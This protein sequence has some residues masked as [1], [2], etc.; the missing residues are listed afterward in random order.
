MNAQPQ[1][2]FEVQT[3]PRVTPSPSSNSANAR[4]RDKFYELAE[5]FA[6]IQS[7]FII[8]TFF[9]KHF[10][11]MWAAMEN[12][13][14]T[15]F[16]VSKDNS[17]PS[18]YKYSVPHIFAAACHNMQIVQAENKTI[19]FA[20]A[21]GE[22]R[23][24]RG[25]F[26]FI[27]DADGTEAGTQSGAARS[28]K[29]MTLED[30]FNVL[31]L[32]S[33]NDHAPRKLELEGG[34]EEDRAIYYQAIKAFNNAVPSDMRFRLDEE[35]KRLVQNA[36]SADNEMA[37]YMSR[38]KQDKSTPAVNYGNMPKG[39][40]IVPDTEAVPQSAQAKEAPAPVKKNAPEPESTQA[41][42]GSA[43]TIPTVSF[44]KATMNGE[45]L[46][47]EDYQNL[48]SRP[49]DP[50]LT[51]AKAFIGSRVYRAHPDEHLPVDLLKIYE[52]AAG[53]HGAS[54]KR[55]DQKEPST[56]PLSELTFPKL[57]DIKSVSG[58]VK[59]YKFGYN[60]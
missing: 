25:T 44:G 41:A 50:Q 26:Q 23:A 10:E 12:T 32:A 19:R 33:F 39:P 55:F 7:G 13:H 49:F 35:L 51:L 59:S 52:S 36:P 4:K 57:P 24:K 34:N 22:I 47:A 54:V 2:T 11:A 46:Q 45:F 40:T 27:P 58:S 17:D 18:T 48:A 9:K 3:G 1:D 21:H 60:L 28:T 14:G 31:M 6:E 5:L 42:F 8:N 38:A 29:N 53:Q 30:A 56:L 16:W 37:A 43:S 15:S 20:S